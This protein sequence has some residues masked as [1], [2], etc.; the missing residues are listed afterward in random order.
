MGGRSFDARNKQ[1]PAAVEAMAQHPPAC[2]D[3][4]IWRLF[5]V[6]CYRGALNNPAERARMDRMQRPDYCSDCARAH[7]E[8]MLAAGRCQPPT[9][10]PLLADMAEDLEA[11]LCPAR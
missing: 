4:R 8:Q 11:D 6:D 3:Q 9:L 5:L 1:L 10:A 2:F 7:R